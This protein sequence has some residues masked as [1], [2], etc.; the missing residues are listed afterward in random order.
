VVNFLEQLAA[1]WYEFRGYYVRRN[2]RVGP[3][4]KGGHECELDVVA[5]HPKKKHLLREQRYK[6]KFEA[7]KKYIPSLFEGLDLPLE[8]EQI[9]LLVFGSPKGRANLGGGK[10]VMIGDFM[11][12]IR[13]EIGNRPVESAAIPEQF[14]LLRTLQFAAK[15][16]NDSPRL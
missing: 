16:W 1:E 13:N 8:I 2:V 7:G 5:F 9:A 11:R 10:I 14:Q 15:Y 3:R 6:K 4:P 12:E